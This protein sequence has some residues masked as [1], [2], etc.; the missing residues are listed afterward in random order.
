MNAG[1][2]YGATHLIICGDIT[3]KSLVPIRQA[4]NRWFA[5]FSGREY[6]CATRDERVKLL[7]QAIR[8]AGQYP[9][10]AEEDELQ[11]LAEDRNGHRGAVFTRAVVAG[12]ERWMK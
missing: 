12:M 5:Q 11:A 8:D 2:F 9:Y 1:K 4:N 7:E 6:D 10:V 3:G